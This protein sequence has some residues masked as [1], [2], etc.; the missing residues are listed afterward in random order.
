MYIQF[1]THPH[2][3]PADTF[4]MKCLLIALII[5]SSNF[6]KPEDIATLQQ[7]AAGNPKDWQTRL[8]LVQIFIDQRNF[9][10]AEKY[11]KQSEDI[12]NEN[13][14]G[15]E[16]SQL[17][18][19]WGLYY[20]TQDNIPKA[21]E[22]YNEAIAADSSNAKAWRRLGYLHEV[23]ADGEQM[24]ICFENALANTDDSASVLYDIGVAYDYMDSVEQ[25]IK[26]YNKALTIND[27]LPEAYLNL[28]VDWGFSGYHD[29]AAYYFNKAEEYG[30]ESIELY[31]NMGV[32]AFDNG[33]VE[34]A[35]ENFMSVLGIDPYYS[36]AMLMLGDI[37][38]AIGDSSMAKVYY[39]E[40]INTAPILYQQNIDEIKQK[41]QESYR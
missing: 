28:G 25:A 40:F 17:Y 22:K 35:M 13:N 9:P 29:S 15:N 26:S 6:D 39:E 16:I 32:I 18:Y 3:I 14:P 7:K 23:F 20:D 37:H 30:L 38:E 1:N 4:N 10:D 27:S 34:Q 11:L 2:L 5:I 8:E 19:L 21:G 33:Q 12:L 31:Y 24:L 36:P 41:L